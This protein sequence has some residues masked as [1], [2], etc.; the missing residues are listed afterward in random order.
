MWAGRKAKGRK[1]L[2]DL[3]IQKW[4]QLQIG[5]AVRI[6]HGYTSTLNPFVRS[7]QLSPS[8]G[9]SG[10]NSSG[11]GGAANGLEH[12]LQISLWSMVDKTVCVQG[13][14]HGVGDESFDVISDALCIGRPI[15]GR[16]VITHIHK[17]PTHGRVHHVITRKPACCRGISRSP[18]GCVL[19]PIVVSGEFDPR[20]TIQTVVQARSRNG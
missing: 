14:P 6:H 8:D 18:N 19:D 11:Q 20:G 15:S 12:T 16:V 10:R 17:N 7:R 13:I 9:N 1:G 3:D 2:A 4:L 5:L